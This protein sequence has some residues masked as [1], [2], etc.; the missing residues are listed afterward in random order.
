MHWRGFVKI[1]QSHIAL[2]ISAFMKV[3]LANRFWLF[4]RLLRRFPFTDFF[5]NKNDRP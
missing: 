1:L 4:A 5:T 2:K 3:F